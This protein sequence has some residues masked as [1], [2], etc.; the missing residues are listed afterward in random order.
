MTPLPPLRVLARG[1]AA[2]VVG[3]L[4][5][6][7]VWFSRYKRGGGRDGFLDWEFSRGLVSWEDAGPPAQI[8][9]RLFEALFARELAGERAGIVNDVMHWSYGLVWAGQ[10]AVVASSLRTPPGPQAG[11]AFGAVVWASDYVVLPLAKVYEPI[12]R[13]DAK[14]LAD[15][16]SAHLVYGVVTATTYRALSPR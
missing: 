1:I 10:Y 9:K 16:L 2:G 15:D 14:T 12:W 5:M 8:G 11:I 4:A 6:D 13:Y 7:L 3:T